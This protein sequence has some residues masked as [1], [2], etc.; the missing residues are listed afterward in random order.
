MGA[1]PDL[2]LVRHSQ[3]EIVP[4]LPAHQW[5]LSE[6]G[7]RRCHALAERLAAYEPAVIASSV[8]PKAIETARILAGL[9]GLPWETAEGLH[10]HD[11]NSLTLL[12]AAEFEAAVA[13][14]FEHP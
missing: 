6:E 2:I 10:E 12:S 8:E 11:R 4:T 3:P 9:L 1:M 13:A 7:R 14:L 5:S